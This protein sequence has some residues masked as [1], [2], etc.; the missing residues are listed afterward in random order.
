MR[1]WR[2]RPACQGIYME[3]M[4]ELKPLAGVPSL[5]DV[6]SKHKKGMRS[7]LLPSVYLFFHVFIICV[8]TRGVPLFESQC[9]WSRHIRLLKGTDILIG[10]NS[11][12]TPNT[13]M[14]NQGTKYKPFPPRA[15]LCTRIVH[16]LAPKMLQV[17]CI[18]DFSL[19]AW[20]RLNRLLFCMSAVS[21]LS[22]AQKIKFVCLLVDVSFG[23]L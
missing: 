2:V 11:C 17:T 3:I 7:S 21:T 4:N 19:C 10:L 15:L 8:S 16:Q 12:Y 6:C 23:Y 20:D 22:V 5:G 14:N 1:S 13:P 18:G 9:V